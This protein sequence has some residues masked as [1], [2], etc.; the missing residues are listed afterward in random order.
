MASDGIF[1]MEELMT[2]E[3]ILALV[4]AL[5][6][7]VSVFLTYISSS[8]EN[9]ALGIDEENSFSGMDSDAR[10]DYK[11]NPV[12][13]LVFGILCLGAGVLNRNFLSGFMPL[14]LIVIA[15]ICLITVA[16][17]WLDLQDDVSEINDL[18]V[19]GMEASIGIGIWLGLIGSILTIVGGGLCFMKKD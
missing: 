14:I 6:I 11:I 8:F 13:T 7:V 12:I 1:D 17:N 5:L 16:L 10:D 3:K 15:L 18:D 2:M 4:G 9:E 19:E